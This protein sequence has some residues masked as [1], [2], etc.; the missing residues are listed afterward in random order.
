MATLS[1]LDKKVVTTQSER[2]AQQA[3][4]RF[5]V[6][7]VLKGPRTVVAEPGG[8]RWVHDGANAGLAMSGSGDVLAGLVV[9]LAARGATPAQ[10][11]VWG[12]GL[13]AAAGAKFA[14]RLGPLG[15]LARELA[16]VIPALMADLRT[17]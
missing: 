15:F 16:D 12:V 8:R 9:G 6:V 4:D 13:H 1:G 7:M 5:A 17:R 2:V 11:S 14:G 10:A 3:A